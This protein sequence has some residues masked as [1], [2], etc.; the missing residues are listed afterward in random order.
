VTEYGAEKD[1]RSE[2]EYL[3]GTRGVGGL[4][5]SCSTAFHFPSKYARERKKGR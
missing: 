2:G 5:V 1:Q 4:C 3:L